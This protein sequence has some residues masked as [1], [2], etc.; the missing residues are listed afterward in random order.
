MSIS[1]FP[2]HIN[3]DYFLIDNPLL[4]TI[5]LSQCVKSLGG[6]WDGTPGGPGWYEHV[7]VMKEG[8]MPKDSHAQT[9]AHFANKTGLCRVI[10]ARCITALAHWGENSI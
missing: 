6:K 9:N 1:S 8:A 3:Q 7:C 5:A 2:K 10:S 4:L